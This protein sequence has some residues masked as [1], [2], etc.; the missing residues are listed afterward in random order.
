MTASDE[1]AVSL[2]KMTL[3]E[4]QAESDKILN[5]PQQEYDFTLL[6]KAQA[7]YDEIVYR[8]RYEPKGYT[9]FQAGYLMAFS[10]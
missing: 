7:V 5:T 9:R 8:Q 1:Y 2:I 3:E 4:L 6:A 10:G